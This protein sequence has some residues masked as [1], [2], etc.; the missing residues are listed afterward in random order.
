MNKELR[1]KL[2]EMKKEDMHLL[3]EGKDKKRSCY[4]S[5]E[6][7]NLREEHAKKL[8]EIIEQEGFPTISKVGEDGHDAVFYIIENITGNKKLISK[9]YKLM[10]KLSKEDVDSKRFAKLEDLLNYYVLKPQIYG[11]KFYYDLDG[12]YKPW[13]LL[14]EEKVNI[15]RESVGLCTIEEQKEKLKNKGYEDISPESA[16]K[17]RKI[18]E[19]WLIE[20]EWITEEQR[21]V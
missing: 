8:C 15:L 7:L 5:P 20:R 3:E 18:M 17:H 12:K 16:R 11:T 6:L 19:D 21:T 4:K 14:D 10:S 2:L 13:K 1:E 9:I